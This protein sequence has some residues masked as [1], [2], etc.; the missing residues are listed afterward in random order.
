[1]VL[2]VSDMYKTRLKEKKN[3]TTNKQKK[4]DIMI[5]GFDVR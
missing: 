1:M 5:F 4:C 3:K 2:R